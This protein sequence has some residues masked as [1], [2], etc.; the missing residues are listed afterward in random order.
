[1]ITS[2][3]L[4]CQCIHPC[5]FTGYAIHHQIDNGHLYTNQIYVRAIQK[6]LPPSFSSAHFF[7]AESSIPPEPLHESQTDCLGFSL[8]PHTCHQISNVYRGKE[9][10]VIPMTDTLHEHISQDIAKSFR[11]FRHPNKTFEQKLPFQMAYIFFPL[12]GNPLP[13]S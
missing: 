11:I 7:T 5:D 10:S 2:P 3:M 13:T 1:M 9:L 6:S 4:H 12:Y 8:F